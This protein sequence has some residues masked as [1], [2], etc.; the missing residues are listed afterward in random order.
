[1]RHDLNI[2]IWIINNNYLN[3]SEYT[4]FKN[5]YVIYQNEYLKH[6]CKKIIALHT[7]IRLLLVKLYPQSCVYFLFKA[8]NV[9]DCIF[10]T[11]K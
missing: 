5:Y 11:L 2:S 4:I 8:K 7:I 6:N 1:M 9:L 3:K 10:Y